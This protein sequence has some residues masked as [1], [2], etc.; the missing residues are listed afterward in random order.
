MGDIIMKAQKVFRFNKRFYTYIITAVI[1][2][3]VVF[4]LPVIRKDEKR[5]SL[6]YSPSE[7][8]T[9]VLLNGK[10]S[11][12]TVPG[13]S[14]SCVRYNS[15]SSACA[16][17]MSDGASYSLYTV[18]NKNITHISDNCTSDFIFSFN[19]KNVIYMTTDGYLYSGKNL[20]DE[21]VSSF[22]VSPDCSSVIYMKKEDNTN[23]LYL[24]FNGK[25]SFV[26]SNYTP[27]AV[28]D[29]GKD[30]Y[31]LSSDNSLCILNADG[32]MKSKLCSEVH[33]DSFL[34]SE[35]LNSI[36]FSDSEYTY[37]SVEGKSKI[38]LVPGKAK[39]VLTNQNE[40]RLNSSGTALICDNHEL[41][42]LFYSADNDN[43]T[44]ELFFIDKDYNRA[45]IAGSVK[46][47]IVTGDENLT[48][49]DSMGKIYK[50]N[51][52]ISEL[53]VSGASNFEATK[54]NRYIYYMTTAHELYSVK[55]SN[56][57]LIANEVSKMYMNN[58]D[59]LF[60]VMID[61]TL[62]S[63]DGVKK[64]DTLDSDVI[65]CSNDGDI[66]Y[67]AKGF[68]SETGT[69]DLYSSVDGRKFNLAVSGVMK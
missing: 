18:R 28:S 47:F 53:V 54:N 8:G 22:A 3:A 44:S 35:N 5:I 21:S 41:T 69:F 62:Y 6:F 20:L 32:T 38:R 34:F 1:L 19:G 42:E 45:D 9:V 61:K 50:Y 55:R 27:L 23:N 25:T 43:G 58:S 65:F 63:V 64:S 13:N 2:I 51:G 40:N 30:L 10:D 36:I 59:E 33:A 29:N 68:R 12:K 15:D 60:V 4:T 26:N 11:G 17:L 56:V 48:Y 39:P 14:I 37:V 49:L 52:T 16:V 7:N 57:Q 24:N 31:V 46:K 66:T 67:F